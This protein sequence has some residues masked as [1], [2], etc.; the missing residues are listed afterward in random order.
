MAA[1][2]GGKCVHE[3]KGGG[4]SSRRKQLFLAAISERCRVTQKSGEGQV[5]AEDT[6]SLQNDYLSRRTPQPNAASAGTANNGTATDEAANVDGTANSRYG[7]TG[8][9]PCRHR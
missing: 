4:S 1:C 2:S 8:G 3:T 9:H 7:G 5:L 6:G